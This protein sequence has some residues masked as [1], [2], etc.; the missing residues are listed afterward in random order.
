[1]KFLRRIMI[2][3]KLMSGFLCVTLLPILS[4]SVIAYWLIKG[5]VEQSAALFIQDILSQISQSVAKQLNDLDQMTLKLY[6]HP[7]ALRILSND[8]PISTQEHDLDGIILGNLLA[9]MTRANTGLFIQIFD[10]VRKTPVVKNEVGV[11]SSHIHSMLIQWDAFQRDPLFEQIRAS[12]GRKSILGHVTDESWMFA[13]QFVV[14]L[15]LLNR[16]KI[17]PAAIQTETRIKIGKD[18]AGVVAICLRETDLRNIY[19]SSHLA[20]SGHIYLANEQG[21]L[22]SSSDQAA[23][24]TSFASPIGVDVFQ[25]FEKRAAGFQWISHAN[26][27]YLLSF[28]RIFERQLI[29]YT[30]QPEQSVMRNFY[31][32]RN[33]LFIITGVSLAIAMLIGLLLSSSLTRPLAA[34]MTSITEI[35]QV[36]YN[37]RDQ[38]VMRHIREHLTRS[39]SNDEIGVMAE[40]FEKMVGELEDAQ[41]QLVEKERLKQEMELA[42]QIQTSLLPRLTQA[43]HPDFEIAATMLPAEEVGGDYYDALIR[44]DGTFWLAIGDVSGHGMTPGLIM[45]MAQTIHATLTMQELLTP[46]EALTR[47]NRMLYLNVHD[48]LNADHFMT[49]TTLKYEGG[50]RFSH[51]GAHLDL[52]VHRRATQACE[53]FDTVGVFLN[54]IP[55][56]GHAATNNTFTME[57]GD[58]LLLYTDGLTEAKNAARELF[59][60]ARFLE[61]IERHAALPP[62]ELRDAV[63]QDVLAW[64]G[65]LRDDDMTLVVVRRVK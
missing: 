53:L 51:A 10:F 7:D 19:T 8:E 48:R 35:K 12:K 27:R 60:V 45:M 37:F 31:F 17:I 4:V 25:A 6:S 16:G 11:F 24:D 63:M 64:S 2:R 43:L 62:A 50:G 42:R 38:A 59:D 20:Q 54:F 13:R 57:I 14:M 18:P 55:E 30:L 34:L 5:S 29:V 46:A 1:M 22:L 3:T 26:A 23:L 65:G 49:F 36:G 39:I 44:P 61:S 41:Q 32:L 58:T 56:I 9:E 33:G 52:I 15:R 47:L 40:M 21:E 28:Q